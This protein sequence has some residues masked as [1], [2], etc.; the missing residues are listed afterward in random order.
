[1]TPGKRLRYALETVAA[2]AVYAL[3]RIMPLDAA[4]ATGGWIARRLG[5]HLSASDTARQNLALAFP[6]KD[7]NEREKIVLG[8]WDN[9]GRVAAEYAHLHRIWERVEMQGAEM[10]PAIQGRSKPAIFYAAHLANWEICAIAARKHGVD[11]SVVYRKPNN[12]GVDSLL[13]HARSSGAAAH[14][15]K[16]AA[17]ARE[18]LSVLK[19]NGVLGILMDQ[20]LNEGMPVPFFGREAM[21]APAIAHFALK[22]DCPVYPMR[23]ERLDGCRFKMTL[24]PALEIPRTGDREQ[25]T[26]AM[27]VEINRLLESWI[28]ERP[29]QWLWIHHRWGS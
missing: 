20:K 18:M 9:L 2:Y 14:I 22:F 29:E 8:M 15:Q 11:V 23:V 27:L 1:M 26:R 6:E 12:P 10:V 4:S 25:D 17:G 5:P 19:R 13:R 24:Y 28:R 3:F 16:G 7:S 21:T